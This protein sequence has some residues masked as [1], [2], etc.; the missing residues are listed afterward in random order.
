MLDYALE[1]RGKAVEFFLYLYWG[2]YLPN[3]CTVYR[4][5][6]FNGFDQNFKYS[7]EN[8]SK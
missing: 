8:I 1:A 4:K 2:L 3:Y 6:S 7:P 5:W